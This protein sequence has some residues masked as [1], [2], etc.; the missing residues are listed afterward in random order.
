MSPA[1]RSI[2]AVDWSQGLMGGFMRCGSCVSSIP[3]SR[4]GGSSTLTRAMC[5]M[6]KTAQTFCGW[7]GI[8]DPVV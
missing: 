8:I 7:C 6:R 4:T 1:G 3:R 5:S 2:S